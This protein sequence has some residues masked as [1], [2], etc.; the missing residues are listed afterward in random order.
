MEATAAKCYICDVECPA[1]DQ[2]LGTNISRTLTMSMTAMLEKCLRIIVETENEYF[3]GECTHKIEEY[4]QLIQ[5]SVQIETELYELFQKK[6][7]EPCYLLDAE[8]ISDSNSINNV[9]IETDEI[10]QIIKTDEVP[11]EE[12]SE[13]YDDMVIEY[14]DEFETQ[15]TEGTDLL[16]DQNQVIVDVKEESNIIEIDDKPKI[17]KLPSPRKAKAN[18]KNR[19]NKKKGTNMETPEDKEILLNCQQCS[20]VAKT[21]EELEE[22]KSINHIDE[23]K[24]LVC[25]IC[26]RSYKSRSSLCVHLGMHNGRNSHGKKFVRRI[27]SFIYLQKKNNTI[28]NPYFI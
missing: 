6:P 2:F 16:L 8:I 10:K 27:L 20:F 13:T 14:L 19:V 25:D 18:D 7:I 4:D 3:C 11:V 28:F 5:L 22:H 12:I 21:R 17:Q 24:R 1:E 9:L 23:I 26:G 15:S